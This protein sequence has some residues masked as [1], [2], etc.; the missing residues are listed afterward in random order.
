MTPRLLLAV[1]FAAA[2]AASG[3][4]P[5]GENAAPATPAAD[6]AAQP[7][8]DDHATDVVR[9]VDNAPAP[10]GLD[11][12]AFAGS[13][14]GTSPC[15]DCAGL[16]DETLRLSRASSWIDGADLMTN[17]RFFAVPPEVRTNFIGLRCARDE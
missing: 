9:E 7:A 6:A 11:V 17:G 15:A 2:L 16:A 13:F 3:C 12:R 8:A 14:E 10:E 4:K 5:S 1:L